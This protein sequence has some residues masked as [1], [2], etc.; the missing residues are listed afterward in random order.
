MERSLVLILLSFVLMQFVGFMESVILAVWYP[1]DEVSYKLSYSLE[2]WLPRLVYPLIAVVLLLESGWRSL[3]SGTF[4]NVPIF[5]LIL[6]VLLQIGSGTVT[7]AILAAFFF[8]LWF[9]KWMPASLLPDR[10]LA[11]WGISGLSLYLIVPIF[12][13]FL[14]C[15][16]ALFGVLP[17]SLFFLADKESNYGLF[18]G[19]SFR[20]FARDRIT[21]SYLCGLT[22]L[23]LIATCRLKWKLFLCVA[24]LFVGLALAGSRAV[25]IAL[26]LSVS[27]YVGILIGWRKALVAV[28]AVV[29]AV[30]V[31]VPI[32]SGRPEFFGDPGN[33][34]GLLLGYW[35][36][37]HENPIAL[38]IGEGRFGVDIEFSGGWVRAHNWVLNSIMNFGAITVLAWICFLCSFCRKLKLAG[39]IV[40]LYF[41]TVGFFH[42]GFDAYLFS[43]EQLSGFLV[44][45]CASN[46]SL[47]A[48][49]LYLGAVLKGAPQKC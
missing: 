35:D 12:V 48:S 37:F 43:I 33:R 26:V 40:V 28:A 44:A 1:G 42:N 15:V 47:N 36:Y 9:L 11:L 3:A 27:V 25:F 24:L 4:L 13:F 20:G 7:P 8:V 2:V 46:R 17:D 45:V 38:L 6:I 29:F 14:L 32:I 18:R 41:T 16:I 21:Y 34:L 22:I 10:S 49:S 23:Y 31:F 19:E 39:R 5:G 30:A